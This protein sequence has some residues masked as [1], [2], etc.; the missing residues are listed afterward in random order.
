[1]NRICI[2]L[3]AV[4]CFCCLVLA[5]IEAAD[6]RLEFSAVRPNGKHVVLI[7]GDEEYRSE[8]SLPMLG[9]ILSQRHGFQCTVLFSFGPP[10]AEF[11]DPNNQAGLRGLDALETADLMIIATRFRQLDP[12]R[13]KYITR[14]LEQGKPIIGLRTATHA[15]AGDGTF[16]KN[17]TYDEFGLKILGEQWVNHHGQHKVQG[18]RS[19]IEP[20]HARNPILRSVGTFFAP[21]DVYGVVHL[22]DED[23]IL[24]R[25]AVTESLHPA[26]PNVAGEKNDPLQ[27]LAWLHRYKTPNGTAE[28][29]SFCTTAGAAVDLLDANLRRL[30]VNASYFLTGQAVPYE[31][32]VDFVDPFFPSFYGFISDN[33]Y[34]PTANRKL[35]DFGLGKSLAMP[36]PPGSPSWPHRPQPALEIKSGQRIAL[37][38]NSLA[39]R[40]SLYGHFESSLH[41]RF[42]GKRLLVRNFGWPA[43]EVGLQQR[44]YNYTRLDDPLA[45]FAPDTFLC[46]FGFNESFAAAD[47]EVD[48][49]EA[50]RQFLDDYL[51]YLSDLT[52]RFSIDGNSPRFVLISPIAFESSGNPLQPPGE[53]ENRR[54][55][56]Y[57]EAIHQ[58]ALKERHRFVDLFDA[59]RARFAE[60]EKLQFT[61]NGV[62]LNEV[63]DRLVARL[64]MKS[65][66]GEEQA[67]TVASAQLRAAVVDKAWHHQQDYR[68][69][70][71]W[72][73]YGGRRTWDTETF[74][75]EY[76][77]IRRMVATRDQFVW[78]IAA[79][80]PVAAQP[81]DSRTG[82]VVVP[83]TMFG[84][85]DESFRKYREP[86]SL[87]YP[88]PQQSMD[89]MTMPDGFEV[90]LFASEQK[91]PQLANPTQ[92]NFD[93]RGRLWVA[94]M[95]NYPQWS[96]A[97]SKPNDR[98]LILEDTDG[99]GEADKSTVF[100]DKLICPTGFEFWNG[101]VLV[102]DQPRVLFLKDT[103]GDDQADEV[104]HLMDGWGSDDTHHACGAWEFSHGGLLYA[105]EGVQ[106]STTLETPWGPFRVQGP[107]GAYVVDPETWK[108]RYFRTPG[109]G[110]PWC[111]VFDQWGNG[112]VGDGTGSNQHWASPLSGAPSRSRRTL[113]TIF[114]N[115]G[116]RPSVGSEFLTTRQFPK[117]VHNHFVYGCVI[118]MHGLTRFDIRDEDKGAGLTGERIDDLLASTDN[119]FRPVDPKV[120]PD[121]ALW[122][123]DWCNPLIGHMQYSQRDPNRDHDHG[124]IYRLVYSGRPLFETV[125]HHDK[126]IPQLLMQLLAYEPR[127]RYRARRELRARPKGQVLDAVDE[128]IRHTDDER[129]MC[130]ALW[131]QEGCRAV[132]PELLGRVLAADDFR[133]RA[134]AVHTL[135]NEHE[136]IPATLDLLAKAVQDE[137]PRVRLEAIRALSFMQAPAAAELA[138]Q[139]AMRPVDYWID[140]TLE[141][142]LGALSEDILNERQFLAR[143]EPAVK[144][145]F[146]MYRWRALPGGAAVRPLEVA[147]NDDASQEDRDQALQ[148]LVAIEGG[149][150]AQG[151]V[152]YER[153]CSSCHQVDGRGKNFG[154]DLTN[155]ARRLNKEQIIRS[156]LRP[157]ESIARGY[158]TLVVET[159][160][161]K[162]FSGFLV[163]ESDDSLTMRI[164]EGELLALKKDSIDHREEKN[165]SSMPEGLF[166]TIAAIEYLDLISYLQQCDS[167]PQEVLRDEW[168]AAVAD[169]SPLRD[170]GGFVELS[171]RAALQ[172]EPNFPARYNGTANQLFSSA[173]NADQD[174][175]D[176]VFHSPDKSSNRPFIVIRLPQISE[177]R[178]VWLQNRTTQQYMGR[179]ESLGMWLSIDGVA[180]TPVWQA[181]Q[182]AAEWDV[183]LP[184]GS[185]ARYVKLGLTSEGILHLNRV[186]VFGEPPIR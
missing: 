20:T 87:V 124:R 79:G 112:I 171:R 114:D 7:A 179:A 111:M 35:E 18:T 53:D 108:V 136:R 82:D 155:V 130:E 132:D 51:A 45:V 162:M 152:V 166:K 159:N 96:P 117:E 101:G 185:K 42:S 135:S 46:F 99:N 38:G 66:F 74:P 72:Y 94:C 104:V 75:A 118:N 148:E 131:V 65:L 175:S 39:E 81:D 88:T 48:I 170:R 160:A 169:D 13:A 100:Y 21:S 121:G 107:S 55:K 28:G 147:G 95:A 178:H 181:E 8:E 157:N 44:P 57:S 34:W 70:N 144:D 183:A 25:G 56:L 33:E 134:A 86:D 36:N 102:V 16:G 54:L 90:K 146:D 156:I 153:V 103:D 180:W 98:L 78:D 19:V 174:F 32:N 172:C 151:K 97:G 83:E 139:A 145:K 110:N 123:G 37:V 184:A 26:S 71:G 125:T 49:G 23:Q 12:E 14:F 150:A 143:L 141:H 161:G 149:H 116:M 127:T 119:F 40:M 138:L 122:F 80:K 31:A 106:L 164:A 5:P 67:A 52:E 142:T 77:K 62:H 24:L 58:L 109:Y 154:P 105:L 92:L 173:T 2:A 167:H 50:I 73:V 10:G 29:H 165:A 59:T 186:A 61:V 126:T 9:K 4:S 177:L 69:L 76:E 129:R 115:E 17:L 137:H 6:D 3:V 168:I 30:I 41:Q 63:G 60:Q 163:S 140:Y 43:D 11:I 128:W 64:L 120:G 1:M 85:R 93:S 176:F 68:M 133:F 158:E 22:T 47:P 84:T 113:R 91:F 27:P 89:Q 182:A 15:F